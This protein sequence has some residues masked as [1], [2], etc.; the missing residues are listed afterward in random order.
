PNLGAALHCCVTE[1]KIHTDVLRI[2]IFYREP[3]IPA[4]TADIPRAALDVIDS[5]RAVL[6][7]ELR[8]SFDTRFPHV[9]LR[10]QVLGVVVLCESR[11]LVIAETELAHRIEIGFG[12]LIIAISNGSNNDWYLQARL[13]RR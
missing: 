2:K 6:F 11:S 12:V 4:T 9:K 10:L 8:E 7:V 13:L 3:K 1:V 5:R